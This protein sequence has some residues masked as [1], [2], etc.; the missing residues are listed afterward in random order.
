[1]R[2]GAGHAEEGGGDRVAAVDRGATADLG[3]AAA[4]V[5][6]G[7][8]HLHHALGSVDNIMLYQQYSAAGNRLA[9]RHNSMGLGPDMYIKGSAVGPT[10]LRWPCTW[11]YW[12]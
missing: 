8:G 9:Q 7:H 5:D 11:P 4:D 1:M 6:D 10:G 3:G 12:A 2:R